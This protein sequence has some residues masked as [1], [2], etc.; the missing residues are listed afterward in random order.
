MTLVT[1]LYQVDLALNLLTRLHTADAHAQLSILRADLFAE[2]V[3][4]IAAVL[5]KDFTPSPDLIAEYSH[6]ASQ[7]NDPAAA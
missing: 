1:T 3:E 2:L 7:L 6:L 4:G 5:E